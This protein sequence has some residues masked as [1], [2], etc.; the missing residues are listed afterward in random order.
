M[1]WIDNRIWI[2]ASGEARRF[3]TMASAVLFLIILPCSAV[4]GQHHGHGQGPEAL[5]L[6]P[7]VVTSERIEEYKKSHP[8]LVVVLGFE[9]ILERNMLSVEEALS[10]MA[11]VDVARSSGVG[12]RISIRG[13]GKSGGV[14]VLLNGRPL[15]ISQYGGVDLSF[16]SIDMVQSITVFKPPVPVWL[17]PGASEGAISIVTRNTPARGKDGES[18][19][20]RIRAAGGSFGLM[21]G[22][23]GHG[24]ELESGSVMVSASGKRRDGKRPNSDQKGGNLSL[25][26]ARELKDFKKLELNGRYTV[27]DHGSPG[28]ADNPTP[29]ARQTYQKASLDNRFSGIAGDGGDYSLNLYG[30]MVDLEDESQSGF[31]STLRDFKWGMKGEYNWEDDES[32]W[33]VRANGMLERDDLDHTLSGDHHRVTVGSGIQADRN[34]RDFT[35][36]LGARGD[37]VSGF[38]FNPGLSGG[39]SYAVT[40]QWSIKANAGYSMHIPS[41]GQLYQSSHGSIDQSRGNPDLDKEKITSYDAALEYRMDKSRFFQLTLFRSNTNDPI[42]YERGDDLIYRPVNGDRAWR[43]GVEAICKY[44]FENGFAVDADVIVQDSEVEETGN[45]LTYTPRVKLRLTLL[46]A[47]KAVGTRLE[48]TARY[49]SRQYSE[50]ENRESQRLDAYVAVDLK[51]IQPFTFKNI[52]MEWFVSIENLFDAD[53]ELHHGYPDDGFRFVSGLNFTL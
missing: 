5:V 44:G 49:R 36:T 33:A 9:E 27:S 22:S 8:N 37:Q 10:A 12:S 24:A 42:L 34:W 40:D 21:E 4:Y 11:G 15:N 47:L 45:E 50:M 51:A 43:H 30:D 38:D 35:L 25:H 3:F 52:P 28:P 39:A 26:W 19:K 46:Y 2:H 31:V 29:D 13:S 1:L 17:G 32:L 53:F 14:L 18:R 41:F 23:V 48:T 20:T 6:D 7:L 16:I